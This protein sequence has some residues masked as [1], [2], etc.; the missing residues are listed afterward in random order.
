[1]GK[2]I[3]P[4]LLY[5]DEKLPLPMAQGYS[6]LAISSVHFLNLGLHEEESLTR[7]GGGQII[8]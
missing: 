2:D 3:D 5:I 7:E 8:A 4:T 6:S 1:M